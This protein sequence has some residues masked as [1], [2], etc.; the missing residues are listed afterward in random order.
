MKALHTPS[1]MRKTGF[2]A[3]RQY[4]ITGIIA[5]LYFLI[6]SQTIWARN[7]FSFQYFSDNLLEDNG[8]SLQFLCLSG[9]FLSFA[10][11]V[12]LGSKVGLYRI[13]YFVGVPILPFVFAGAYN[14]SVA[15]F[16]QENPLYEAP[17]SLWMVCFLGLFMLVSFSEKSPRVRDFFG[18]LLLGY[19][20][21]GVFIIQ[22]WV[23]DRYF[24]TVI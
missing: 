18:S 14:T 10:I 4:M 15:Y 19:V 23:P 22:Y 5:G 17:V 13:P 6:V 11:W 8:A 9:L 20:I 16:N 21:T 2:T 7:G 1:A 24:W 12:L 3:L